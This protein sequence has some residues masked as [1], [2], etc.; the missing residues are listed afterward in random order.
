MNFGQL[1]HVLTNNA[2]LYRNGKLA[3]EIVPRLV[4][5]PITELEVRQVVEPYIVQI[6]PYLPAETQQ[7]VRTRFEQYAPKALERLKVNSHMHQADESG[8]MSQNNADAIL[9]IF[10]NETCAPLD[11][12]LYSRD[13]LPLHA[14]IA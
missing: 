8:L 1:A 6:N 3:T 9:T 11:L 2:K 13:L 7:M 10:V 12:A 4:G 5:Q 14:E